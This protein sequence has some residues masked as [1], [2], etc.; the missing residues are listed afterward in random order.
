MSTRG[1]NIF[2]KYVQ[3]FDQH[4][5]WRLLKENF[6][7]HA[8]WYSIAVLSMAVVAAMTSLSAWLM[9]DVINEMVV[10]R[11]I[12]RVFGF[13]GAVA[14]IFF[15]KGAAT[16]VQGY[17][18][19]RAGNSIIAEQQRKIYGRLLEQGVSFFQRIPSSDLLVRVTHNAQAAR[20]V[21]DVIVT[22]AV[23]DLLSLFGLLAVMVI[24]QPV[25]SLI[26]LSV[27]PLAIFGVRK[28]L[29]QARK[30][31]ELELSSVAHMVQTIQETTIGIRIVKAFALEGEL[32][33]RMEKAIT[34][35]EKQANRIARLES[36]TSPIM[37]TLGGLAIA[38]VIALSAILVLQKGQTPGELMSFI[39][40]LLLSYEPAKR[41]AR[42][43][44]SLETGMVGV[45]SMFELLDRPISLEERRDAITLLP[46]PGS[47]KFEN[48][49]FC[50]R[51]GH[52]ILHD[53]N[54]HFKAG[55]KTALVGPSGGGKST[56]VNLIMR[57]YDPESGTIKIDGYDI[58]DVTFSSLRDRMSYVGQDAFLFA[59]SVKYNIGL[60]RLG[61]SEEDIIAAAEAA[62]AHDFIMQ[63]PQGY[64][65][66]VGENGGNLSGG[67]K[68]RLTIARAM[69]RNSEILILDEPT[70]ALDSE[71]EMLIRDALRTLTAGRTTIIIAH[72]LSTVAQ[73]DHI[74]VIENGR[75][76]EEG[77][78]QELLVN[79]GLYRKL[80]DHQSFPQDNRE[81]VL[82]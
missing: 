27:G 23:R 69:L 79:S 12:Y 22:S 74:V 37:E 78:H 7:K 39:T 62:N 61:A 44:I 1:Y 14:L 72:R 67:Q 65:T 59:G 10:S 51:D 73:A 13:A 53:M 68:Q 81:P 57:L 58:R 18:L 26:S 55:Q 34:D 28:L 60:G 64:D 43:R 35:V 19:S 66:D 30:F 40:A 4:L 49:R 52:P 21:I 82:S 24:Q 38:G 77:S 45:R 42:V 6:K 75:I 25:L 32:R 47:I 71:S 15:T 3:F 5:L 16:F 11:D 76:A 31:M 8:R 17:Y 80:H 63:M 36:A 20:S 50:Y 54:L 2:G 56:I 48:V 9:R 46:G 29:G 33:K 70:S 41:L